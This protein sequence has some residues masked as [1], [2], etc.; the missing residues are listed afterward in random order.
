VWTIAVV[1][2]LLGQGQAMRAPAPEILARREDLSALERLVLP[3]TT[4]V[5]SD[6]GHLVRTATGRAAVQIPAAGYRPRDYT[7]A[8]DARWARAG[9]DEAILAAGEP[10]AGAWERVAV[11]GRFTRWVRR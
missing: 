7:A 11:E 2:E 4:P 10:P 1:L 6:C 9:V 5:L 8:D 3:G